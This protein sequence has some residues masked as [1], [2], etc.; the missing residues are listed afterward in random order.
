MSFVSR[1]TFPRAS[2]LRLLNS[3]GL[4]IKTTSLSLA[5]TESQLCLHSE[6]AFVC[7]RPPAVSSRIL[8]GLRSCSFS[9]QPLSFPLIYLPAADSPFA[10]H[11]NPSTSLHVQLTMKFKFLILAAA[12]LLALVCAAD[13]HISPHYA[14]RG[15]ITTPRAGTTATGDISI[16]NRDL[17]PCKLNCDLPW[18]KCV[19]DCGGGGSCE[20]QCNCELFSNSNE[21]CR[22][23]SE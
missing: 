9:H 10:T 11:D 22:L 1:S 20:H 19:K 17:D 4:V 13:P 6:A 5:L 23:R 16:N 2:G 21:L 15:A 12:G 3:C 7:P 14:T 18:K 8:Y